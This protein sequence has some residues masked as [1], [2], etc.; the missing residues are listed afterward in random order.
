MYEFTLNTFSD[1]GL[2]ASIFN[3]QAMLVR[4]AESLNYYWLAIV[5]AALVGLFFG[6]AK[7]LLNHDNST[8]LRHVGVNFIVGIL[9]VT[10]YTTMTG[11]IHIQSER[12]GSVA[13][14]DNVPILSFITPVLMSTLAVD[15]ARKME[16]AYQA[17]NANYTML[18][19][20]GNQT[21][22]EPL[23]ALLSMRAA[24]LR[25]PRIQSDLRAIVGSCIDSSYDLSSLNQKITFAG[26]PATGGGTAADSV[27][28]M[29]TAFPTSVGVL[30]KAAAQ[31]TTSFVMDMAPPDASIVALSCPSAVDIVVA[32]I[33]S[34]LGGQVFSSKGVRAPANAIDKSSSTEYT[35]DVLSNAYASLRNFSRVT[36]AAAVGADKANAEMINLIFGQ[37]LLRNLDCLKEGGSNKTTCLASAGLANAIE[38]GNI[39]A[40]ANSS[41]F[42][43]GFG[44]FADALFAVIIGLSPVFVIV[45]VFLGQNLHKM[46]YSYLQTM[47][48]S[49][50]VY[51]F[52][53]VLVNAIIMYRIS[54]GLSALAGGTL[55]NQAAAT[56]AYRLL[57]MQIGAAASLLTSLTLLVPTLFS[58]SQSATM[59]GIA[60]Q[61]VGQGRFNEKSVA[62][63]LV[64]TSPLHR[65]NAIADTSLT[66]AGSAITKTVGAVAGA[67]AQL[68]LA[69]ASQQ[70]QRSMESQSALNHRVEGQITKS[71]EFFETVADGKG[72]SIGLTKRGSDLISDAWQKARSASKDVANNSDINFSS[73]NTNQDSTEAHFSAHGGLSLKGGINLGADI[74]GR[75]AKSKTSTDTFAA[76]RGSTISERGSESASTSNQVI[77]SLEKALQSTTDQTHREEIGH[78]I[79]AVKTHSVSD[80]DVQSLTNTSRETASIGGSIIGQSSTITDNQIVAASS[81]PN[82]ALNRVTDDR[83]AFA[84]LSAD[85]QGHYDKSREFIESGHAGT[86]GGTNA[87]Q[88]KHN[89]ATIRA[90]ADYANNPAADSEKRA[91]AIGLMSQGLSAVLGTTSIDSASLKAV[92]IA[93]VKQSVMGAM[94]LV[95]KAHHQL[96]N[97]VP[98]QVLQSNHVDG[99]SDEAIRSRRDEAEKEVAQGHRDAVEVYNDRDKAADD[100]L[101]RRGK[102]VTKRVMG[103]SSKPEHPRNKTKP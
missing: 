41:A 61:P 4:D 95:P 99:P 79:R 34:A 37:E 60:K 9:L 20:T 86:I 92:P 55:I 54:S 103:M 80:S 59:A 68:R 64:E 81:A 39:D 98:K 58:L 53:A 73:S 15:F 51:N 87:E 70:Y 67:E 62:P 49:V 97:S 90:L 18:G 56:E 30:L 13:T 23:R 83:A 71:D 96:S 89:L 101:S 78:A 29:D 35:F 43:A 12:D 7:R 31:N 50:L 19:G 46:A 52:G 22:G 76:N 11:R 16:T 32:E 5:I 2:L 17:A 10:L 91:A 77:A 66:P 33:N 65:V 100:H 85:Y 21:F 28:I 47:L 8:A 74:G 42:L 3:G 93:G 40:A 14:V 27:A 94:P 24:L 63:T 82:S 38:Q 36:G 72:T 102:V 75:T 88:A 84:V 45:M 48:W 1:V 26:D 6:V 44:A 57:S 25:L 69:E